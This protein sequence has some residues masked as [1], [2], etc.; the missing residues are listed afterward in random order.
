M[1]C[2]DQPSIEDEVPPEEWNDDPPNGFE[3]ISD[4]TSLIMRLALINN[5]EQSE[6][7][8]REECL[9]RAGLREYLCPKC[10]RVHWEI[11]ALNPNLSTV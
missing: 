1:K 9:R 6:G 4:K 5:Y 7:I 11:E 10:R 2:E 8:E 3:D